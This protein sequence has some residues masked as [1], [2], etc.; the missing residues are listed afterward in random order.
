MAP[1]ATVLAELRISQGELVRRTGL[2]P[3]TVYDAYHGRSPGSLATWVRIAK[4]IGVPLARIAPDA[5]AELR[6]LIVA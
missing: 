1:L 4:A 6:G 5:A 3:Q 2:A